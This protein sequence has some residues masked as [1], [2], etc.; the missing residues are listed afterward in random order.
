MLPEQVASSVML[1]ALQQHGGN[2]PQGRDE[3]LSLV[4][5]PVREVLL[6]RVH[7][8]VCEQVLERLERAL[9]DVDPAQDAS[10]DIDIDLDDAQEQTAVM[11]RAWREPVSVVVVA[12]GNTLAQRLEASL[13]RDRVRITIARNASGLRHATFSQTPLIVVLDASEAPRVAPA[14]LGRAMRDLPETMVGIVWARELSFGRAVEPGL[15][16]TDT[17]LLAQD[18]G[19]EPLLDLILARYKGD[20]I[21][22]QKP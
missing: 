2:L 21:P 16:G 6:Q 10:M 1:R 18:E 11:P 15:E 5:G 12:S 8:D 20:S 14:E 17:L 19:Y 9:S 3:V 22:P 13:G 7:S 4:R